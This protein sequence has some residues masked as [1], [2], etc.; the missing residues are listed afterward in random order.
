M[1]LPAPKPIAEYGGVDRQIFQEEIR[2]Q[3]QPAVLRG[4]AADWPAVAAARQSD[5]A[6]IDYLKGHQSMIAAG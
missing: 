6:I 5:E 2:P 3:G 1:P 4:L